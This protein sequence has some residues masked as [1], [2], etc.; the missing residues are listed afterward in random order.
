MLREVKW[1][2]Q[3]YT[4]GKWQSQESN[5]VQSSSKAYAVNHSASHLISDTQ[6]LA[7]TGPWRARL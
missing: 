4:A 5:P 6:T 7:D 1:L 3:G 2:A